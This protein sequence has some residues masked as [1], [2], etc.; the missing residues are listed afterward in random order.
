M[1]IV[2]RVWGQSGDFLGS[3]E[4]DSIY[5]LE[6]ELLQLYVKSSGVVPPGKPSILCSVWTKKNFNLDSFRA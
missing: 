3:M 4:D 1:E 6:E 5:L 2:V